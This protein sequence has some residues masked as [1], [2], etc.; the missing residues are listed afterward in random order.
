MGEAVTLVSQDPDFVAEPGSDAAE[1][2][3]LLKEKLY[4]VW[5]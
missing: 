1:F 2:V 3:D 5:R 4:V